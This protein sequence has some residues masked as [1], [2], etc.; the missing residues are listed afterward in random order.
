MLNFWLQDRMT[1]VDLSTVQIHTYASLFNG[2]M[3][4]QAHT[5]NLNDEKV[6]N[7]EVL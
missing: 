6:W 7:T 5:E 2:E 1:C 4:S 3:Y